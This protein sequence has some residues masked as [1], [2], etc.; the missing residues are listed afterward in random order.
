MRFIQSELVGLEEKGKGETY[1]C[2]VPNK[3][4]YGIEV[5]DKFGSFVFGKKILIVFNNVG[6]GVG[7]DSVIGSGDKGR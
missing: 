2:Q 5:E 4:E 1:T 7:W 3:D 6:E